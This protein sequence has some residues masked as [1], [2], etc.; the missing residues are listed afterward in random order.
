MSQRISKA[1]R[2]R[3]APPAE[4]EI[5]EVPLDDQETAAKKADF[6][7]A[8]RR[9]DL[10]QSQLVKTALLPTNY[11]TWLKYNYKPEN[12]PKVCLVTS[13][14]KFGHSKLPFL[15]AVGL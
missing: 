4:M 6:K 3:L 5:D 7:E 14:Q 8:I 11:W 9:I 13:H 1:K 2:M 12:H 10:Y 15:I